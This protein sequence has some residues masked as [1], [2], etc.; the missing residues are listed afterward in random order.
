[1]ATLS[2]MKVAILAAEGF[3]QSELTEPR[4]A[5]D[6]A[7]AQTQVVSPAKGEVQ[8]WK[9]F[10]KAERIKVDVPLERAD[11]A[12]Y[13]A[14]LLPGGVANPD[15]LRTM[16]KAVQFVR[17]FFETGKPV[18]AICHGPWTLIEAGVVRGRTLTSWPSL[19]TDLVNAGAMWVDQEVCVDH[20]LVSSR[21][22]ADIPAF[23]QKM[24]EEFA[25]GRATGQPT[26]ARTS[27]GA[28]PRPH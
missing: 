2:G 6:E 8:G 1:M 15:Q 26:A 5:L 22:P 28:S 19:K 16:P 3:E 7:G 17:S 23:N 4:K 9:H 24:I 18:A 11:A 20:G 21:K 12:D 25:G 27:P 10:D 13:D 14:L